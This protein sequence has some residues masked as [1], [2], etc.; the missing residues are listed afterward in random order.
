MNYPLHILPEL[1]SLN[2]RRRLPAF[3]SSLD[4]IEHVSSRRLRRSLQ[5]VAMRGALMWLSVSIGFAVCRV[6]LESASRPSRG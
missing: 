3:S 1:T 6:A 5:T 2:A 4:R